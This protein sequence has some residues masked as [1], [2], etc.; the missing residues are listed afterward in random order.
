MRSSRN[1][2]V[3]LVAAALGACGGGG[4]ASGNGG[5]PGVGA[6]SAFFL[7]TGEPENTTDPHVEVDGQGNLHMIYRAYGGGLAYYGSCAAGCA[8]P[9]DV[10]VV[11][12][13]AEASVSHMALALTKAGKPRVLLSTMQRVHYLAC[14]GDCTQPAAWDAA[15][16]LEHGGKYEVSGEALA[17]T[18]DGAPRFLFH[19]YRTYAG[20]GQG[21]PETF[22]MGC[23]AGCLEPASWGA[24]KIADQL[25]QA[26]ALRI[27][28]AGVAHLATV[29]SQVDLDMGLDDYGAYLECSDGD[30]GSPAS[31]QGTGLLRAFS[32]RWIEGIDPAV[33]LALTA[34]GH[35][36]VALLSKDAAGKRNLSWF[37]CDDG[38]T[39]GSRFSGGVLVQSDALDAGLDLALDAA[40]R[41]RLAYTGNA[42]VM[43]AACDDGGCTDGNRW[44]PRAVE[45]SGDMKPDEIIPYPNCTVAAWVLDR[46]T[47]AMGAD[48][49]PR[50]AYVATDLSGGTQNPDPTKP[51]CVAGP[52]MVFARFAKAR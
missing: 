16:V 27:D 42:D 24:A 6:S 28:A 49:A 21:A 7:P 32:S 22:A 5:K 3:L 9:A 10:K 25:W 23:D 12:F 17:L 2:L 15:T 40:G 52:D 48:G 4:D 14:D 18:P 20:I 47:L 26:N 31:W 34:D 44:T 39:S 8:S 19:T 11:V 46:P 38:C 13:Q 1:A 36:R 35:P 30:C 50:V 41:P 51:P 43:V 29:V 37:S 45:R 33:S